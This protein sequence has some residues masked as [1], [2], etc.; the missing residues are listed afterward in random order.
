MT[1]EH[2]T[3]YDDKLI[4]LLE[5]IWGEGY[6]SP[7]SDVEIDMVVEGLDLTN[8]TVLDIGCG[9]GGGDFRLVERHNA[10]QVLGI[11]IET[12]V[13]ARARA[14]AE[15]RGLSDRIAFQ[16]VD[17][18]PLPFD[19]DMF[20][21]VFSKDAIIHIADKHAICAD[22]FRVLK[23]G[24]WFA[25]S[26]WMRS[27]D[28]TPSPELQRYIDLEGLDFGMASPQRYLDALQAAGFTDIAHT[29]RN[30]WYTEKAAGEREL[31]AGEL[32]DQA[33]TI[34][35]KDFI[36]HQIMVWDAMIHV[37]NTGEHRPGHLR[38]HKPG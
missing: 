27:D 32:Y 25:A 34:V 26:D 23:P 12:G 15:E 33:V 38:A 13:I 9:V 30:S 11:D 17:P 4:A 24:G 14:Y 3:E 28:G 5:L 1:A 8:K 20:D 22:I 19:P 35:G 31:L 29:D 2:E 10:G 16:T 36:D 18:G 6:L 37:L 7:G 21:V